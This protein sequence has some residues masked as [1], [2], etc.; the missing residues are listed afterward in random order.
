MPTHAQMAAELLRG[1]ASF[2]RAMKNV[3]PIDADELDVNAETCEKVAGLVED[4]PQGDAPA[5]IDGEVSRV[6][7][8]RKN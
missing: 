1:A 7:E 8:T 3:Y 6:K 4:D 2:F 5:L